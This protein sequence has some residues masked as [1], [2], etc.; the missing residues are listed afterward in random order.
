MVILIFL[1]IQLPHTSVKWVLETFLFGISLMQVIFVFFLAW[2]NLACLFA[3]LVGCCIVINWWFSSI[4]FDL[5]IVS[6]NILKTWENFATSNIFCFLVD[7]RA[8]EIVFFWIFGYFVTLKACL[9]GN[10][11]NFTR[12][13][14]N[15]SSKSCIPTYFQ[16]KHV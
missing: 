10:S 13:P 16:W 11:T 6:T 9:H 4:A 15:I 3:K 7:T 8:I 5:R 1:I 2:P 12:F 14:P